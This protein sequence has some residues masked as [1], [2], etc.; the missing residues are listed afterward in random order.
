MRTM[1]I[2]TY[3]C[4][5]LFSL[6]STW[7]S[8]WSSFW[9]PQGISK[10]IFLST[11]FFFNCVVSMTIYPPY[12]SLPTTITT[13][14]SM[15]KALP[16]SRE[17]SEAQRDRGPTIKVKSHLE[18]RSPDSRAPLFAPHQISRARRVF[19][20]TPGKS[21]LW[22]HLLALLPHSLEKVG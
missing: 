6:L 3:V 2:L 16:L 17:E 11:V 10:A 8:F 5:V 9:V 20:K 7:V 13:L 4:L 22:I 15:A 19:Y 12:T 14:L 21:C 1:F 18:C